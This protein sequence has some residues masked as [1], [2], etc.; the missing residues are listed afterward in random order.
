MEKHNGVYT[1]R[2]FVI[3]PLSIYKDLGYWGGNNFSLQAIDWPVMC[4][5]GRYITTHSGESL[6]SDRV[7]EWGE[8]T[9][10][11]HITLGDWVD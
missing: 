8:R 1:V 10:R 4:V 2:A 11:G 3:G 7:V 9:Y 6:D 5:D